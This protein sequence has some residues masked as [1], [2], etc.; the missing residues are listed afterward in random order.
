MSTKIYSG[1]IIDAG[2]AHANLALLSAIKEP[3]QALVNKKH[4]KTIQDNATRLIDK[5]YAGQLRPKA[6]EEKD[7]P[8]EDYSAWAYCGHTMEQEQR[9]CRTSQQRSPF[10]D[11]D[12]EL[13]LRMH[14]DTGALLGYLQ[15]ERVG[16]YDYLL[17]VPGIREYGY[18]NNT[19]QPE[20]LTEEEWAARGEAWELVL[21]GPYA[22]F[23]VKW[24]PC[25]WDDSSVAGPLPSLE[26]RVQQLA[27]EELVDSAIRAQLEKEKTEKGD[28]VRSA[29]LAGVSRAMRKAQEAVDTEGDPLNLEFKELCA[30][31]EGMLL[32]ELTRQLLQ[33][34]WDKLPAVA[35][36]A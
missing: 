7:G 15:E 28:G 3:V 14:P 19:D 10:Y 11:C 5:F 17:T 2:S 35:P 12:V 22:V 21:D 27:R 13:F 8:L 34:P 32:P 29:S 24:Q 16:V 1:F 25:S 9:E 18:W 30:K 23:C 4:F 31:H 26:S 20:E 6:A 33:T 36:K